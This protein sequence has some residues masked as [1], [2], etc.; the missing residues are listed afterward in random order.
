MSTRTGAALAAVCAATFCGSSDAHAE[1]LAFGGSIRGHGGITSANAGLS[2]GLGM[3]EPDPLRGA[4]PRAGGT[5]AG[6]GFGSELFIVVHDVRFGLDATV[7]FT[8]EVRLSHAPLAN[9]FTASARSA[10]TYDFNVFVGRAFK[11]GTIRPYVDLRFGLGVLQT[12][13][14]LEHP[15]LGFVGAT[16]YD[17]ARLLFGPRTGVHIPL[18][19]LFYIDTGIE[20]GL[21]GFSRIVGFAGIAAK[22]GT[23]T[24]PRDRD[25]RDPRPR[26]P[27]PQRR[28]VEPPGSALGVDGP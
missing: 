4:G 13:I 6:G 25:P 10:M 26:H 5:R 8:D 22:L 12:S 19:S 2:A 11:I 18:T 3:D 24:P 7:L 15:T 14:R 16:Q 1:D 17:A 9:G 28:N 20:V 27:P 21:L 23:D